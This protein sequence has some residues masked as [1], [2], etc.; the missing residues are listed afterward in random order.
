MEAYGMLI[1]RSVWQQPYRTNR[2][3]E[4]QDRTRSQRRYFLAI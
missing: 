2:R 3:Y 4:L 1:I